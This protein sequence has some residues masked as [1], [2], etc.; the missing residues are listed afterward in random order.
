[1]FLSVGRCYLLEQNMDVLEKI[2]ARLSPRDLA[3]LCLTSKAVNQRV[4]EFIEHYSTSF[5]LPTKFGQF[6]KDNEELLLPKEEVLRDRINTNSRPQ[7]LM[8]SSMQHFVGVTRRIA[9][10][11]VTAA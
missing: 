5:G 7:L 4:R 11:D 6:Y 3:L 9:V 1:M 2:F 8:Y 10:K